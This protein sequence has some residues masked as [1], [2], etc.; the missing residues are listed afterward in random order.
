MN[1]N[2]NYYKLVLRITSYPNSSRFYIYIIW[3][4]HLLYLIGIFPRY[5]D[6][7]VNFQLEINKF[8]CIFLLYQFL[9]EYLAERTIFASQVRFIISSITGYGSVPV[10]CPVVYVRIVFVWRKWSAVKIGD[11]FSSPPP[12]L[13]PRDICVCV[14]G[15]G[16]D[17]VGLDKGR[18]PT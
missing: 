4:I 1:L 16:D 10:E 11:L 9:V 5:L 15:N 14:C 6:G 18:W 17:A 7:I 8:L 12:P 2:M 13:K 3:N